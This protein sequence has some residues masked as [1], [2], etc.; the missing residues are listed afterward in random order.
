MVVVFY[1]ESLRHPNSIDNLETQ[2]IVETA[3]RYGCETYLLPAAVGYS[4]AAVDALANLP[5][6]ERTQVGIWA[7]FIPS[8]A[9]Y[10]AVYRVAADK[11]ICLVNDPSQHQTVLEFDRYYPLLGDLT[12]LSMTIT[13][14]NECQEAG[15]KLGFPVFVRGAVKSNKTLGWDACVANNTDELSYIVEQILS[16]P[17]RA[18]GRAIIRKLVKLRSRSLMPGNFPRTR[19]YRLFVYGN[20]VL[21]CGYYWDEF[22][23][24]FELT[25]TDRSSL[26]ELAIAAATRVNVPYIIVDVGQLE[27]GDWIVIEVG[28]AQFAGMS[29]VSIP[30]LWSYL[31]TIDLVIKSVDN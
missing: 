7:G 6:F 14:V 15:G 17:H 8:Q 4:I 25:A 12:P 11:N 27:S 22:E 2:Q 1:D 24:E 16:L 19:E 29:H 30:E 3:R 5:N 21:A 13:S 10:E 28:D 31:A 23:D 9:K 20:R 26:T 18:R